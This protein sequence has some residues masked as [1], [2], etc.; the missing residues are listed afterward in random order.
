MNIWPPLIY[1]A[2]S[3]LELGFAIG[4]HGEPR[5][6]YSGPRQLFGCAL[7]WTILLWGGF[8]LPLLPH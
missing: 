3:A 4:K 8:F 7:S 2:L 6:P 1:L 5:D